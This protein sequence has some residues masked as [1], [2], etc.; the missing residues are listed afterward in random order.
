L[1]EVAR[2]DEVLR[3]DAARAFPVPDFAVLALAA[4][5]F[6]VLIPVIFTWVYFCR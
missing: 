4:P 3:V 6:E 2:A 1:L 5:D